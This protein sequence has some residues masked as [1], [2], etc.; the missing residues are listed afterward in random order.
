MDY[1]RLTNLKSTTEQAFI[2]AG[3]RNATR[4]DQKVRE[5]GESVSRAQGVYTQLLKEGSST[6]RALI[7]EYNKDSIK[8]IEKTFDEVTSR[9]R[10]VKQFSDDLNKILKYLKEKPDCGN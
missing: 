9:V 3:L 10:L 6:N 4:W 1:D 2:D 8:H 5:I 7:H